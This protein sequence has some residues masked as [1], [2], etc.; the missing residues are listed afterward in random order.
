MINTKTLL[1]IVLLGIAL[2]VGLTGSILGG[3]TKIDCVDG[4]G[5]VF[6]A[7]DESDG[8]AGSAAVSA[9]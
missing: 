8:L 1:I 4:G 3:S 5:D 6:G 7:G 2:Y 9:G